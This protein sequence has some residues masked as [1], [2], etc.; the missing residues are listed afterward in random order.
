MPCGAL[1]CIKIL[2]FSFFFFSNSS[3][4][5]KRN[6]PNFYIAR[7]KS[8]QNY[9]S[10]ELASRFGSTNICEPQILADQTVPSK[11]NVKLLKLLI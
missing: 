9:D 5:S 8:S 11:N 4:R 1:P 10:H 7:E 2:F 6:R 3:C